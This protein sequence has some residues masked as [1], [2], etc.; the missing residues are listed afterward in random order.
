MA[1]KV[2]GDRV[3][4]L[5]GDVLEAKY[6]DKA[7]AFFGSLLRRTRVVSLVELED[8]LE[9][10]L[11][12]RMMRDL[13]PLDLLVRG[14]P[15]ERKDAPEVYLAVEVSVVVDQEDVDRAVRRA[16]VLR[17]AGLPVIPTVAG[18]DV[19]RGGQDA[20]QEDHVLLLQDGKVQFWEE[21]LT[22]VLGK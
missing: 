5:I 1:H 3:A 22:A 13:L 11:S 10:H 17:Q 16:E 15:R 4:K 12:P 21:A 9:A 18:E 19:T 8:L 6:R 14:R 2:L 7:F 20:A